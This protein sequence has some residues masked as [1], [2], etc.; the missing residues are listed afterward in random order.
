[1]RLFSLS[2][3]GIAAAFG[4]VGYEVYKHTGPAS[5]RA[6]V[7]DDVLVDPT[8]LTPPV[9]IPVA[10]ASIAVRVTKAD[11]QSVTGGIVGAFSS[12]QIVPLPSVGPAATTTVP[13]SAIVGIVKGTVVTP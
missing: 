2:T 3:L 5:R 13:R 6:G 7:G 11:S 9:A 12:G 4:V 10:G 1:M 8:K